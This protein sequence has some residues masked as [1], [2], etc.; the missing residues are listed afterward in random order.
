MMKPFWP[1]KNFL[2]FEVR[3][4]FLFLAANDFL[5]THATVPQL[6]LGSLFLADA[7]GRPPRRTRCEAGATATDGGTRV[8]GATPLAPPV[9]R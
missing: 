1:S 7:L 4:A 3:Y 5:V 8:E 6:L 2:K 9:A